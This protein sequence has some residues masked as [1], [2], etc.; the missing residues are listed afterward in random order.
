LSPA[1]GLWPNQVK[2]NR[3]SK[4]AGTEHMQ[5]ARPEK[6]DLKVEPVEGGITISQL[7]SDKKKYKGE[8]VKIRGKVTKVNPAIM[9]KNWIHIQDGTSFENTY[10]LTVT[11]DIVPETGSIV[12]AEGKI[13]LNKDFG[14]G[15][16]YPVIMEDAKITKE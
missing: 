11:S 14:Y 15:Y 10:D 8:T 7:L 16:K 6:E 3:I 12:T 4:S 2:K 9:K 1:A 13:S 5:A